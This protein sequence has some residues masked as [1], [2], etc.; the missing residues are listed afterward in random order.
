VG[1]RFSRREALEPYSGEPVNWFLW[2]ALVA[3]AAG[4]VLFAAL[5]FDATRG[6][7]ADDRRGAV[8]AT[9][10]AVCA[11]AA[12]VLGIIGLVVKFW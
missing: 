3:A 10:F 4:I 11:G 6:P 8:G 7:R 9:L 12:I 1:A 2:G 5:G